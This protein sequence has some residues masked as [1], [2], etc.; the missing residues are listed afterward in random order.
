MAR[1]AKLPKT[2]RPDGTRQVFGMQDR[3]GWFESAEVVP[4]PHHFTAH[5][6]VGSGEYPVAFEEHEHGH[7]GHGAADW[8]NNMR[9]AIVHVLADAAVSVA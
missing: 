7:D 8:D 2:V 4:E 1:D 9:A 3:G 5:V 6:R